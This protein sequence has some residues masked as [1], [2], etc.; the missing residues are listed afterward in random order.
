M[1]TGYATTCNTDFPLGYISTE[2]PHNNTRN[3]ASALNY[4]QHVDKYIAT[5]LKLGSILGPFTD[6]PTETVHMNPLM[7]RPKKASSDRRII[8]DLSFAPNNMSV[9]NG[10]PKDYLQGEAI[11]TVLPTAR[12]LAHQLVQ[13]GQGTYMYGLDLARAYRQMRIDPA[14]WPLM[15]L[16]W[17]GRW[18]LDKCPAFGIRLGAHFCCRMTEAYCYLSRQEDRPVFAYIDDVIGWA[19]NR[20]T[21]WIY[22]QENR[23]LMKELGLAEAAGKATPPDTTVVWIGVKFDT[24]KMT[25]EI[26]PEKRAEVLQEVTVW[27]QEKRISL[28]QLQKLLGKIFHATKCCQPAR[29]FCNRLLDGL[30]VAYREGTI[31]IGSDMRMDLFWLL[32]FLAKFNG[33]HL[34]R[35]QQPAH[36]ITVDSCLTG[37]G[38]AWNQN[39]YKVQYPQTI[40]DC[41]FHISQLEMYNLLLA[42]RWWQTQLKHKNVQLQCDNA[43]TVAVL[44]A[45][46]SSDPLMRGCAREVWL[47]CCLHDIEITV[48]HIPGTQNE[49]ADTLSRAHLGETQAKALEKLQ[50]DRGTI[51][52]DLPSSLLMPPTFV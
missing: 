37:G 9:N 14:D 10:I 30:R 50:H 43:A 41:G 23:L 51:A 33:Q 29:L 1:T 44:Q 3:H 6:K 48:R 27:L 39:M 5:E 42:V 18:F 28:R 4:S 34:M 15:G 20:K 49:V 31:S 38:G 25:M 36:I 8:M 22:F 17:K 47:L 26:P 7:S 45:G 12:D 16:R 32:S 46:R 13:S 52:H 2:F 11:R 19:S 35:P 40:L 24:L 21:A